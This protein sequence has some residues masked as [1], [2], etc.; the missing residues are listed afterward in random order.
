MLYYSC[1]FLCI[2]RCNVLYQSCYFAFFIYVTIDNRA[3][4]APKL[5]PAA[6]LSVVCSGYFLLQVMILSFSGTRRYECFL[7]ALRKV[8]L[9]AQSKEKLHFHFEKDLCLFLASCTTSK[10]LKTRLKGQYCFCCR[11]SVTITCTQSLA[12]KRRNSAINISPWQPIRVRFSSYGI[13]PIWQFYT[14]ACDT[15]NNQVT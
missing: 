13:F 12:F 10:G 5:C 9:W 8:V 4:S 1:A 3:S 7:P 2:W 11:S 6:F 15:V 14:G